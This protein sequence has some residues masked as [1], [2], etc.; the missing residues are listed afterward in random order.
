MVLNEGFVLLATHDSDGMLVLRSLLLPA[1]VCK[2]SCSVVL[3]SVLLN[4][5][6]H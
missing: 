6:Q 3:Y 1:F 5:V 2:I 4:E